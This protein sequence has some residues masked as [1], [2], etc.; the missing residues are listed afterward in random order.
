[1]DQIKHL[2]ALDDPVILFGGPYSNLHALQAL[3][4]RASGLGISSDRIISAGD[5]VAYCAHGQE[6]VDLIR[7]EG[8]HVVAGNCEK[9]LSEEADDCGCG[10]EEGSTCSILS[11]GWY[12][13]AL[14][15]ITSDAKRWMGELPDALTF[16]HH[17]KRY[18]VIHG[19]VTDISRFLWS[20][21]SIT[22]LKAEIEAFG[23]PIDVVFAAHSGIA[24]ERQIGETAWVNVGAVGMPENDGDQRTVFVILENG[25]VRFE[26]L[27]Y[28]YEGAASAR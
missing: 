4:D 15:T 14:R 23:H 12:P 9:Q 8:I 3:L 5:L 11:N 21:S 7:G 28:D 26:R 10:F 19:G 20:V 13:H 25:Q 17:G 24:F 22:D 16:E 6:C 18:A 2:G 27:D 1:M